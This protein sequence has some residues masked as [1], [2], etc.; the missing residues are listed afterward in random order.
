MRALA[1]E[2]EDPRRKAAPAAKDGGGSHHQHV[3]ARCQD[4]PLALELGRA[5]D[6]KRRRLIRLQVRLVVLAVEDEVGREMHQLGAVTPA[7]QRDVAR[8]IRVDGERRLALD[9]RTVDGVVGGAVEYHLGLSLGDQSVDSIPVGDGE[10]RVR[11]RAA[12]AD[13][14]HELRAELSPGPQHEGSH[15]DSVSFSCGAS[16]SSDVGSATPD[17]LRS[18]AVISLSS[19][20]RPT[21]KPWAASHPASTRT[22]SAIRSWRPSATTRRPRLWPRPTAERTIAPEAGSEARADTNERSILI[23]FNG[24]RIR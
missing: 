12:G 10:L 19:T 8:S 22:A 13:E 5:I 11:H 20:G 15:T 16:A 6:G 17:C 24:R 7:C 1:R 4:P 18:S 14:A 21:R 2:L 9:L 3:S 23:S